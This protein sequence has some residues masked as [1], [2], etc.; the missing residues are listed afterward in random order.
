MSDRPQFRIIIGG[1]ATTTDATVRSAVQDIREK[2]V[3]GRDL[4]ARVEDRSPVSLRAL[5]WALV[6]ILEAASEAQAALD[7]VGTWE[8]GST[9]WKDTGEP[10]SPRA[11]LRHARDLGVRSGAV[12]R[13]PNSVFR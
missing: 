11:V 5:E 9:D 4:L 10:P 3:A 12:C 2:A 7:L 13:S 1:R 8:T 6:N